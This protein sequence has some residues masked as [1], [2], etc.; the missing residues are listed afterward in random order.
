[1]TKFNK[2]SYFDLQK[3]SNYDA[4]IA[5]IRNM[6]V[7]KKRAEALKGRFYIYSNIPALSGA[8][9]QGRMHRDK[10]R[11]WRDL[12][13]ILK[14]YKQRPNTYYAAYDVTSVMNYIGEDEYEKQFY[15][16]RLEEWKESVVSEDL[17]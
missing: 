13:T 15:L 9:N 4:A 8:D 6:P 7:A 3:T 1:M 5:A 16:N 17:D 2:K 12:I 10:V 14:F 11:T